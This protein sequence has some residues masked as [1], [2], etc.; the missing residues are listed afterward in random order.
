VT[1]AT[2]EHRSPDTTD[3][4]AIRPPRRGG[5]RAHPARLIALL[6]VAA[7]VGLAVGRFVFLDGAASAPAAGPGRDQSLEARVATL[8][9]TVEADPAGLPSWQQLGIAYTDRAIQVGDPAFYDLAGRA[10]DRAD[11]IAPDDPDTLLGRGRLQLSLHEF[12]DA[13]ATGE[14]A[15]AAR[16]DNAASLGVLVDAQVELGRYDDAADTLQRMLD[17]SPDLQA[18]SRASYLRELY[19]DLDGA[20]TAMRQADAAGSDAPL[21]VATIA[22]FI[23][24]LHLRMGDIEAARSAYERAL[25]TEP[26]LPAASAGLARVEA[27]EG[28][29]DGA[30]ERLA[31]VAERQP[32]PSVVILQ[33]ELLRLAGRDDEAAQVDEVARAVAALQ[34]SAG[35]IV[36]LEMALFE[37]TRG[38]DADGAVALA[39]KAH[40]ARPDNVYANDALGWALHRAGR[41]AEAVPFTDAALRL[42]TTDAGVLARAAIVYDAAGQD[43]QARTALEE[44]FSLAPWMSVAE[45]QPAAELAG[46]LG[47]AV[48]PAWARA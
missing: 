33:T 13:L 22:A 42:G 36:D 44:A 45:R 9:R 19:G 11:E 25:E 37:A 18:L 24:D 40:D 27:A 12:S 46:R 4:G 32:V 26:Q 38:T 29:V 8:E 2:S 39:Q 35:Q 20:L 15:V 41:S 10:F 7:L 1:T 21:D 5:A 17:R 31:A 43:E 3:G 6:V 30:I 47:I 48:P 14:A 28:D 34:Q 16:P 23:G